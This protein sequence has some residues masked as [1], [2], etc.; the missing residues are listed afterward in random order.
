MRKLLWLIVCLMTMVISANA[1]EYTRQ[2]VRDINFKI[3][4]A[5]AEYAPLNEIDAMK[6]KRDKMVSTFTVKDKTLK[7]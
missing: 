2:D 6:S 1:Q 7:F 3:T 5:E 4:T